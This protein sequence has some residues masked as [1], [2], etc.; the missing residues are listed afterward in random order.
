[1]NIDGVGD[2]T[3]AVDQVLR[4]RVAHYPC[5][6]RIGIEQR[7]SRRRHIDSVHRGLEQLAIALLGEALFGERAH[8]RLARRVRIE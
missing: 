5:E 4:T 8:R 2:I 6:R 1:M 3:D 7:P